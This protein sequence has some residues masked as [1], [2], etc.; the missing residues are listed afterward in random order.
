ME[1][2]RQNYLEEYDI[3]AIRARRRRRRRQRSVWPVLSLGIVLAVMVGFAIRFGVFGQWANAAPGNPAGQSQSEDVL[4]ELPQ[5]QLPD[6]ISIQDLWLPQDALPQADD[7]VQGLEGSGFNVSFVQQPNMSVL[8]EQI[9]S[10]RFENGAGQATA[11]AR[12]YLFRLTR[13]V[14][15]LMGSGKVAD[16][17]SFV[18]DA[19]VDASFV[20]LSPSQIPE[21]ESGAFELV[22]SCYGKEYPVRYV[23]AET[24]PPTGVGQQIT[25]FAGTLPPAEDLVTDIQDHSDVT[26]SYQTTPDMN[27]L[28]VQ[29]VIMLLTDAY[30][31]TSEVSAAV[32]VIP[33]K[34]G[35]RFTGL[36]ELHIQVGSTI[37]YKAGVTASDP[38]DGE[39]TFSVNPGNVD[40]K[41]IGTYTASYTA[42][43]SSGN[44]ITAYRTIVVQ[45]EAAA[46]VEEYAKKALAKIITQDMTIDQKIYQV[47]L[48]TKSN[49]QFIG[50]SDKTS[51]VH[52]AYEGFSTGKGD[53]Y[54]YY[55]MNVIMLDLLGIENLEVRRVGGTS[56][57]WWNL[58]LHEDGTYYHVDSCPKSIYLDGISYFRMTDTDLDTYTYDDSVFH[59]RPNYYVY[60]KTLPE[61][62]NISIAP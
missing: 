22:I 58:V 41:T 30:G 40:A 62:Q 44:T 27:I 21:Q 50:T 17:R 16:V 56:N 18:P 10:L 14:T 29:N 43:D 34:D 11:T 38:E 26:V 9:V 28:G 54:T 55:A 61:Y 24:V 13:E 42:T 31:N 25:A 32:E 4:S 47:Y 57:H 19:G 6:E 7:F 20:G 46:A 48:Y 23:I 1:Y 52:G 3:A 35:P 36:E 8:G 15:V 51:V 60:D 5:I 59:H 53:C 12:L 45:D 33:A 49:V 39:L 37:S 2:Y